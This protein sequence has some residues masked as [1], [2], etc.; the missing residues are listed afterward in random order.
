[1]MAGTYEEKMHKMLKSR[2]AEIDIINDYRRYL[3]GNRTII[4]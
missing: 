1:M 2:A 4:S 3:H